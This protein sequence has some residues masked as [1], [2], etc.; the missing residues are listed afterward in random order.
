MSFWKMENKKN[1]I[2][3]QRLYK[4]LRIY[5]SLEEEVTDCI[6]TTFGTTCWTCN[7]APSVRD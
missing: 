6:V 2:Q 5:I 7:G 4:G 1:S 3:C